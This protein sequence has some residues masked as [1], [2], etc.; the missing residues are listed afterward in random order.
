MSDRFYTHDGLDYPDSPY[1]PN[2]NRRYSPET[3]AQMEAE[4]GRQKALIA[5]W[6]WMRGNTRQATGPSPARR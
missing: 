1:D 2:T 6:D 4:L 3:L 5:L